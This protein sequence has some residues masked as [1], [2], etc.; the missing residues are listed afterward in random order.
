MLIKSF[1]KNPP[2]VTSANVPVI[3][4]ENA[5]SGVKVTCYSGEVMTA[6]EI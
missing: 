1:I 3:A 2:V 4:P 6:R 5:V